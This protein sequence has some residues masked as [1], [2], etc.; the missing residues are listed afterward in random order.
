M[1]D[2]MWDMVFTSLPLKVQAVLLI[3][4]VAVVGVIV[5]LLLQ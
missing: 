5:L 4:G 3:L 2:F 1:S